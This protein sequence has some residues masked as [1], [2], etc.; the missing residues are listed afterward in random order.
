[1][2]NENFHQFYV[3]LFFSLGSLI[4]FALGPG[5]RNIRETTTISSPTSFQF[6]LDA[7]ELVCAM[8]AQL[9]LTQAMAA[10]P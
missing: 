8:N 7:R 6:L 2:L 5:A 1:M 10:Q 9:E 4:F 3:F